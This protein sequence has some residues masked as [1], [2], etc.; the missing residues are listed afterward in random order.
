MTSSCIILSD[1]F[2]KLDN[3]DSALTDA[4]VSLVPRNVA[5]DNLFLFLS[6]SGL[7]VFIWI[8]LLALMIFWEE[9][10]HKKFIVYFLLAFV[11]TSFLVNILIK[12]IIKRDRPYVAKNISAPSCPG[13][14]GF[15]SG[16][17]AGAFAGAVV[18]AYFD[19]KRRYLYFTIASLIAFSRIYLHCHYLLDIISGALI[20]YGIGKS[21]F[22]QR[23]ISLWLIQTI[24]YRKKK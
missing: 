13:D 22:R 18:F 14:F 9:K 1:M 21:Y 3:L 23:R 24:S 11:T 16:H 5:F 15:P 10:R 2:S 8:I 20:G 12:N 17:A 19:K 6:L 7:T 4:M